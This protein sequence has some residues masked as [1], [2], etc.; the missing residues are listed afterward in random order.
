MISR[1]GM[2]PRVLS[3]TTL[4]TPHRGSAF[5]DWGVRRFAR[6]V[7]PVFE[8]FGVLYQAFGT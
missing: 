4:G 1:L 7:C 6:L 8:F 2:A 5:A 3:L